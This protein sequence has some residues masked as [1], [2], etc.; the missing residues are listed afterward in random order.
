MIRENI[1]PDKKYLDYILDGKDIFS[2]KYYE[3]LK[4]TKTLD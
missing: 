1:K 2:E 4:L 3:A